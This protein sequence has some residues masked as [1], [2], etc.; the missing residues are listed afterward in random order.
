M[1]KKIFTS[2]GVSLLLSACYE[3]AITREE[4]A[5]PSS[6]SNTIVS[7]N[8][9][10]IPISSNGSSSTPSNL[11]SQVIL[12]SGISSSLPISS[13]VSSSSSIPSTQSSTPIF[14]SSVESSVLVAIIPNPSTNSLPSF[15]WNTVKGA[16]KYTIQI[17][18]EL[19][20]S[21]TVLDSTVYGTS[22]SPA[23]NLPFGTLYWRVHSDLS[24]T[25]WSKDPPL[26]I[27]CGAKLG[28]SRD[29]RLYYGE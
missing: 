13:V 6:S 21:T 10:G 26:T 28:A 16:S 24:T 1:K 12:S 7:G 18:T 14:S 3:S 22:M 5:G 27:N 25:V 9:S 17:S 20:F 23:L 2:L 4:W 19:N 15:S 29:G 8:S 11:S